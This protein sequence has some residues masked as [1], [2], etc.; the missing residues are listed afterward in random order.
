MET[1]SSQV[2]TI[3]ISTAVHKNF[4]MTVALLPNRYSIT[5]IEN[6]NSKEKKCFIAN[7]DGEKV[8]DLDCYDVFSRERLQFYYNWT[9][10][11]DYQRRS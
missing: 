2:N 6:F 7:S 11:Y 1:K 10:N 3:L 5:F 9:E 4:T 8:K